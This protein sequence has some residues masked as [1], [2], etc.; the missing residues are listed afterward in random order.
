MKT[1]ANKHF[2]GYCVNIMGEDCSEAEFCCDHQVMLGSYWSMLLILASDWSRVLLWLGAN[3]H[4]YF[5][6]IV[7]SQKIDE[8]LDLES[9]GSSL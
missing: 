1:K 6:D 9:I 8:K 4:I 7:D 2:L 3:R 5:V